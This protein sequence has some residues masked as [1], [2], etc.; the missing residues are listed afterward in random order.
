M[1]GERTIRI[2]V[3]VETAAAGYDV[4]IERGALARLAAYSAAV[5]PG[6]RW[7][8]LTDTTVRD[9]WGGAALASFESAGLEAQTVAFEPGEA[10][11]SRATWA[12]LTDRLIELGY[13]R[14]SGI[15][16]LGGGVAGDLAGFVAATWMRG[17]PLVQAPTTLLAMVDASVGGKTGLDVPAGKNLVGAF[18]WPAVVVVDP[19]VLRTLPDDVYRAGFAEAVKHAAVADADHLAWLEAQAGALLRRDESTLAALI[20]RSIEIKAAVVS[21]DPVESGLRA[22]LNFGHTVGHAIERQSDYGLP[23]G[24]AVAIGMV[25]EARLGERLGLTR[26]GTAERLASLLA[27][28]GL[29]VAVPPD[30]PA[31]AIA[32]HARRDKKN[33]ESR[34]RCALVTR[35]G[36]PA[37]TETGEWAIPVSDEDLRESLASL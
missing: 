25:A 15:V 22:I 13:G 36:E 3:A 11:K 4:I 17:V 5:A 27:R 29:P 20:R 19:T 14:D 33:R 2:P 10:S 23:H 12:A 6:R 35:P 28:L 24:F 21:R 7:A 16:A 26:P 9:L 37:R 30:M 31:D 18:K 34:I 1:T 8:I 32:G